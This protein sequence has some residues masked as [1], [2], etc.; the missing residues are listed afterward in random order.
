MNNSKSNNA[1]D[2]QKKE[3]VVTK[4]DRKMQRRKE[5]ELKRQKEN[6]MLK[7]GSAAVAV[8]IVGV[9]GYNV[10]SNYQLKHGTYINVGDHDITKAEVD[11]Y[12]NDTVNSFLNSYGSYASYFGLDTSKDFATQQYTDTLTWEDYFMQTAVD[13][14]KQNYGLLDDASTNGFEYDVTED[15]NTYVAAIEETASTNGYDLDA[16]YKSAFGEFATAETLKNV[17]ENRLMASAYYSELGKTLA[18]EDS[19]IDSYY[20]AN[21]QNFDRVDYRMDTVVADVPEDTTTEAVTTSTSVENETAESETTAEEAQALE[22]QK[23]A[24]METAKKE[25]DVKLETIQ[26]TGTLTEG[27]TYGASTA[28]I[29]S[30]LFDESRVAG[31]KTVIEDTTANTYYVLAF[32]KRY[33]D[34]TL[35]VDARDILVASGEGQ[36]LYEQWQSQDEKTEDSFAKLA[37]ENST[38][39]NTAGDGGLDESVLKTDYDTAVTDWLYDSSR[40]AGDTTVIT[41]DQ[42]DYILYYKGTSLPV[43]K[44]SVKTALLSENMSNYIENLQSNE[45]VTDKKGHLEYLKAETAQTEQTS[46]ETQ[47]SGDK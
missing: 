1:A 19:E 46:E 29:Q 41:T 14:L 5:E 26:E 44:A 3:K 37:K 31:D 8:A 23:S 15:Y 30:W 25:A 34:E 12:Y 16:Y 27:G 6:A 7:L 21:K 35:T 22:E 9:V 33:R 32:E 10:Y 17:I 4:Y 42:G 47:T 43:W 40:V 2:T 38:D 13:S 18:P 36:T 28:S 11:Y 39:S 24:A 45:E 20:S